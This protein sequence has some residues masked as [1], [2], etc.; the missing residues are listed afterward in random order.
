MRWGAG[1]ASGAW[2]ALAL[3]AVVAAGGCASGFPNSIPVGQ[4]A[5]VTAPA[6][7]VAVPPI[8]VA[9]P[10]NIDPVGIAPSPL[11]GGF[12]RAVELSPA[13]AIAP[14]G[15]EV[16]MVAG[17]CGQDGYL[18]ARQRVEWMLDQ[19]GVGEFV[20]VGRREPLD[21]LLAAHTWPRKIDNTFAVGLTSSAAFNISRGTPATTDDVPILRGQAWSS[22]TSAVEGVSYVT[23]VAPD[24]AGW[25]ARQQTAAIHWVDAQWN[26]PPPAINAVGSRHVFTTSVSRHTDQSPVAGWLV[27]YQILDGPAAG[28]APDGAQTI[29]VPTDAAG[30]ASAEISQPQPAGG[31]NNISVEIVRPAMLGG[32]HLVIGSGA[33]TATWS[34]PQIAVRLSGPATAAVGGTASYRI[35]ISNPGDL[36]ATDVTV[37][38]QIPQ[39]ASF[40]GSNPAAQPAGGQVQWTIAS[41][42]AGQAE[43]IV[44]DLRG[45]SA[46]AVQVCAD[47]TAAAGLS[48]SD[49]ISTNFAAAAL[50][51]AMIGPGRATVGDEVTFEVTV[52]NHGAAT[53]TGLVAVSRYDVGLR[54]PAAASPLER[55]LEDLQP[56]QSI[57]FG[58][59]F[60]V[61]SE[62][63][64]CNT[65]EIFSGDALKA[66]TRECL[67]AVAAPPAE[68]PRTQP[69]VTPGPPPVQPGASALTVRMTGPDQARMGET[70]MFDIVIT[71]TGSAPL[72]DVT[73]VVNHDVPLEPARATAGNERIGRDLSWRIPALAAGAPPVRYQ[74]EYNLLAASPR[75][76]SRVTVTSAAGARADD[77]RCLVI[78]S[79]AAQ[80]EVSVNDL[81]DPIAV[82]NRTVYEV[83]VTNRSPVP[84]QQ[85]VLT[86]TIPDQMRPLNA[87]TEGPASSVRSAIRGQTV[88]FEPLA[89]LR[90]E[91]TVT[92]RVAAQ[93]VSAGEDV[94]TTVNLTS[95]RAARAVT[96]T[97]STTVFAE[98]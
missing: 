23:A 65:V 49:C 20:E 98:P 77:E 50:D 97:A 2:S 82:D 28:F 53:A 32:R 56:G 31:T 22:I 70:A 18:Q 76:C 86:V 1:R 85:V 13:E 78:E 80:L 74:V 62:G 30:Q 95:Q 52:T 96:A 81:N 90:A 35:E 68:V 47:V 72:A 94:A 75:A 84:D 21:W 24:V 55:T 57:T 27:R 25:G 6:P 15:T 51:V 58:I 45:D 87:G 54:H 4:P 39:G 19:G 88:T 14:V 61:E 26:F 71:N 34:A 43:V 69:D 36:A 5:V 64:L 66:Q 41:L 48:A 60:R 93:A 17:V 89:E 73:I 8:P 12:L 44:I 29:E 63:E 16:V 10:V 67:T 83:R 38:S 59:T 7:P 79:L 42:G 46:G 40:V 91:E 11:F 3:C 33:T 92:F 9:P 37:T